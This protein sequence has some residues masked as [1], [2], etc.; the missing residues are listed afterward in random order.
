MSKKKASKKSEKNNYRKLVIL[1]WIIILGPIVAFT[2]LMLAASNSDLP[3]TAELANPKTNLATEV[4]TADKVVI[5][6]YYRENRSDVKFDRLPDHL[7]NALVATE[8]ARY[9]DHS[10][11][12]FI[13]TTRAVAYMGSKGGGSTISQQ[14]AKMLFT[15]DYTKNFTERVWQK[16]QEWIIAARLEK[17]Y[18]KDEIIALYLNRY[19]FINQAVG[20]KSAAEIY[21]NKPVDSLN[22]QES[23][24]LVGMLKN[25]AL[26]NPLRR[27]Q[28]VIDRREVVMNQMVKYG[29]L[30]EAA[31]DSLR[32]LPLGLDFQRVSHDE[33]MAPYFREVVR[34][35]VTNLLDE[36][37]EEG[38]YVLTN[39][40][41]ENYDLYGDG[42]KIYTTL[43]SR[44]QQYAENAVET[45]IA[46]EL[47]KD[48]WHDLTKR[49]Y[50]NFPFY[51]GI[52]P[53]DMERIMNSAVKES[54][55]YKM[56]TGNLCPDCERPAHYIEP[57][58]QEGKDMFHCMEE[59]GGCGH[60]WRRLPE[61]SVMQVF[62]EPTEMKVFSYGG[63]IDTTMSPL[64]SIRYHKAFL[65]AGLMSMD[66]QTGFVRAWVGGVDFKHY[67]FDNVYQ[68]R[69]QVG[70]TFKPFVYATAIRFGEHPCTEYPNQKICIDM[71]EGQ[72]QWCPDNSDFEYGEMVTLEYALANS[73]NTITA[74]L[75]KKYGPEPV[76]Q[77]ARDM[78][79]ESPL[80]AVPS[81]A[82]G[83]AEVK[84]YEMVAAYSA[85][86][87]KGVY[88][89]PILIT[90]IEDKNGNMIF[91]ASPETREALD[92]R[93]AYITLEMMKGVVDGAYNREKDET[94]GTGV[95]LRMDVAS[96]KYDNIKVP[97]AGKTG[98]T[99][100]N[101]DGWFM[102]LTPELVTGVWVGAQDPTVRFSRTYYGQGA[103]TGLPIYGYY[104]QDVYADD[105]L[106][107]SK[108]DFAQPDV[109]IGIDLNCTD[110]VKRNNRFQ[111]DGDNG[112][113]E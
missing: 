90:R 63:D 9:Y 40:D 60:Y 25:S 12:D 31:Y 71:P 91:E 109:E 46:G 27:E 3:K 98:T 108:E 103:N 68:S 8:D 105:S 80:P 58:M 1:F 88:I 10:G 54:R 87:N 78:G 95:R 23:A 93:S 37:D 15:G 75:I 32:Q 20:I 100:N 17:R 29:F 53:R 44:M 85:L 51:N 43:D 77:L 104:M 48:F 14:L 79:I 92:E 65:H 59:E 61:D 102:G 30:E 42:L 18:T 111:D 52:D 81:I 74:M 97:M 57:V 101:T 73:I 110:Y 107:I 89:E 112:L 67:K 6:R 45:H 24:M 106:N 11:I 82:L 7:V 22:V 13:G 66:P 49:R 36:K 84:L 38:N 99:Q 70:S 86:V 28:L 41:G 47:Q 39:S 56:M 64:D 26:Y 4:Y 55:R 21:F 96:R 94:M 35:K 69:R 50:K 34:K 5:G 2:V 83:V 113:F 33:G 19:D 76:I 16:L 62:E 72:P